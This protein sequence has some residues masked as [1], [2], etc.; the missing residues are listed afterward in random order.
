MAKFSCTSLQPVC[1]QEECSLKKTQKFWI[2]TTWGTSSQSPPARLSRRN[3]SLLSA[4]GSTSNNET[5][6]EPELKAPGAH[7]VK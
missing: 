3:V 7:R 2:L 5:H 4:C 1:V 6:F